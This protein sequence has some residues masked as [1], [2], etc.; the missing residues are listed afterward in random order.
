MLHLAHVQSCVFCSYKATT[1][2]WMPACCVLGVLC[3]LGRAS[4]ESPC[5]GA[6]SKPG[7]LA[8]TGYL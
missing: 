8:N 7:L 5:K 4:A 1:E 6:L 2:K 3:C